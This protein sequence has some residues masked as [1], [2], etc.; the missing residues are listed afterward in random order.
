MPLAM[1]M[2][3]LLL[4]AGDVD[5]TPRSSDPAPLAA[6]TSAEVESAGEAMLDSSSWWVVPGIPTVAGGVVGLGH[7]PLLVLGMVAGAI[8]LPP[9]ANFN[10]WRGSGEDAR[11][12]W[13]LAATAGVLGVAA[14]VVVPITEWFTWGLLSAKKPHSVVWASALGAGVSVAAMASGVAL[15]G[16]GTNAADLVPMT[17]TLATLA[18]GASTITHVLPL[19]VWHQCEQDASCEGW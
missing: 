11:L 6:G 19:V 3:A 1:M 14:G 5:V 13:G 2:L 17:I 15:I 18:L 7:A 16:L 9:S 8:V 4:L 10:L 12:L